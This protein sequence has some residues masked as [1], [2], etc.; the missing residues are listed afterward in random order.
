VAARDPLQLDGCLGLVVRDVA[1]GEQL[2][3][4]C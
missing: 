4:I 1:I 3:R 2:P